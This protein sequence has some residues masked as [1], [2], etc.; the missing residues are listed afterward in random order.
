MD[1]FGN[2]V[3][4]HG[5]SYDDRGRIV[6]PAS[7]MHD[8]GGDTV[9]DHVRD[10]QYA[11]D[12]GE[13]ICRS[14]AKDIVVLSTHIVAAACFA[15]LRK[16]SPAG[17][18]FTVLRQRDALTVPRDDLAR[19]VVALRDQLR[20]MEKEGKVTLGDFMRTSSGGDIIE[21]ALRAF[22]GFHA[23]PVLAPRSDG[24]AIS[25]TNVLF[26]YQNRL[27]AHGVGWD[28]IAPSG[29]AEGARS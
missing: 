5:S 8:V 17:D 19:D 23:A 1:L 3:D 13:Q 14:Y 26:Y 29:R 28:V 4:E 20:V 6:D 9:I 2:R 15:R 21:R 11:R 16:S 24:L 22:Q 18:L 7:Y 12:L 25:D 10:A 27:A